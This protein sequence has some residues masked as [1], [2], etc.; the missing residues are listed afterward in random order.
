MSED[1]LIRVTVNGVSHDLVVSPRTTL[2]DL[3]RDRLGLTGTHIT[4]QA[5]LCGACTV[6]MDGAAVRSCITLAVQADDAAVET[7]ESLGSIA[8][9]SPLQQ[10]FV[11]EH[12]LQCGFCTPGFLMLA[13]WY[14]RENPEAGDEAWRDVLSANLC[15][16]T[17]YRGIRR[18]VRKVRDGQAGGPD[19]SGSTDAG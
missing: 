12:A 18:A 16:C 2:A 5:G 1:H 9:P 8:E 14:L 10:A 6:I 11:D 3:L 15:R 19:T 13:T 7:V 17:G 4:C